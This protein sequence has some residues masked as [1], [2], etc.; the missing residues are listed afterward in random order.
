MSKPHTS[1][2]GS[3]S[4]R[5]EQIRKLLTSTACGFHFVIRL[6]VTVTRLEF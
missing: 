1:A 3:A 5:K 4:I 2:K 6:G